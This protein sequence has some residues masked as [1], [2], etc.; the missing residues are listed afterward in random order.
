MQHMVPSAEKILGFQLSSTKDWVGWRRELAPPPTNCSIHH[1]IALFFIIPDPQQSLCS[2]YSSCEVSLGCR[3]DFLHEKTNS[4]PEGSIFSDWYCTVQQYVFIVY[5][6]FNPDNNQ[7]HRWCS[8]R[9]DPKVLEELLI[10]VKRI[11]GFT[12]LS[13][14]KSYKEKQKFMKKQLFYF[15]K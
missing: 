7:H 3:D 13:D 15:R 12:L 4:S 9:W 14:L 11:S 2:L 10:P 1:L 5:V 8:K 6:D